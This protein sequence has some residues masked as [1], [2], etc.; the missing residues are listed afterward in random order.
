MKKVRNNHLKA[1]L[2][3][4][5]Y[6]PND[7]EFFSHFGQ[8]IPLVSRPHFLQ[9]V[10]IPATSRGLVFDI[11]TINIITSKTPIATPMYANTIHSMSFH[12]IKVSFIQSK[13]TDLLKFS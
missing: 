8:F 12:M 11:F 9:Y 6:T 2:H 3:I 13:H 10:S 5:N 4:V 7:L 1:S